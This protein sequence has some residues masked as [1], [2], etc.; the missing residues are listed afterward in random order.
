MVLGGAHQDVLRGPSTLPLPRQFKDPRPDEEIEDGDGENG[1]Y[2]E[3]KTFGNVEPGEGHLVLVGNTAETEFAVQFD[4]EEMVGSDDDGLCRQDRGP[5][6][7]GA[8]RTA[9]ALEVDWGVDGQGT[10]DGK[11]QN[12]TAGEIRE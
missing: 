1:G 4:E 3:E 11:C 7:E 5:D 10:L 2:A 8:P 6:E 12:E 9:E